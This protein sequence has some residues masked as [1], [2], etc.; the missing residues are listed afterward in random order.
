MHS[1]GGPGIFEI[2][3]SG[4]VAFV[5]PS[6]SAARILFVSFPPQKKEQK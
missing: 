1:P 5:A 4:A 2:W 6:R 3:A